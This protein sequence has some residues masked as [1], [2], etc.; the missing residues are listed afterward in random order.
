[1]SVSRVTSPQFNG[2]TTID[3]AAVV[4]LGETSTSSKGYVTPTTIDGLGNGKLNILNGGN[5]E[6]DASGVGDYGGPGSTEFTVPNNISITGS[7]AAY[8]ARS[9]VAGIGSSVNVTGNLTGAV[10]SCMSTGQEGCVGYQAG[11]GLN[12]VTFTGQVTLKGNA[13]VGVITE[14]LPGLPYALYSYTDYIFKK[15]IGNLSK[16]SLLPVSN[17]QVQIAD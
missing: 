8:T 10:N 5:L 12:T 16:Y 4:H 9:D 7:G 3:N 11:Q 13:Q 2:T 15:P 6:L 14:P 17:S 1:M